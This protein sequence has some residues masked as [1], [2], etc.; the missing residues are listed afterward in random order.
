MA[1]VLETYAGRCA[2]IKD[3][4]S[5]CLKEPS[6]LILKSTLLDIRSPSC[7]AKRHQTR[8][9]RSTQCFQCLTPTESTKQQV[10]QRGVGALPTTDHQSCVDAQLA[11]ALSS[12]ATGENQ[13]PKSRHALAIKHQK[14][15]IPSPVP[16][17]PT[18]HS[19]KLKDRKEIS[20][21]KRNLERVLNA[22][23]TQC[24]TP[25]DIFR[26]VDI[27][28]ENFTTVNA[29]TAFYRLARLSKGLRHE[30][31]AALRNSE[32]LHKVARLVK[33]KVPRCG[34]R[35]LANLAW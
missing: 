12:W 35:S 30:Q 29:V 15:G 19:T 1:P 14:V 20:G 5:V 9:R 24:L 21:A 6:T 11:A 22:E 25:D 34:W 3:L 10:K 16:A 33:D 28:G 13:S 31:K 8:K 23:L 4:K 17:L 7:I 2:S 18:V 27:Y 32:G 26:I